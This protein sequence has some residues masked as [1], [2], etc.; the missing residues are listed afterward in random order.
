V[1]PLLDIA[2]V[3]EEAD[4]DDAFAAAAAAAG[5]VPN[6]NDGAGCNAGW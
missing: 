5:E 6:T 4:D 2:V 1:N 3:I